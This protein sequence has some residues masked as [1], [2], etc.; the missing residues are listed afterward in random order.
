[1]HRNSNLI[2]D[3][4]KV[5]FNLLQNGIFKFLP[6]SPNRLLLNNIHFFKYIMPCHNANVTYYTLIHKFSI[7]EFFPHK[8]KIT[9]MIPKIKIIF[10]SHRTKQKN[11]IVQ[12]YKILLYL[13]NFS[14]QH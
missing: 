12:K 4:M 13:N 8:S 3:L 5:S 11:V 14:Y 9:E 2:K 6:I 1:M 10:V 7:R